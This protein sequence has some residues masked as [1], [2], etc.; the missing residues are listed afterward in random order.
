VFV[1]AQTVLGLVSHLGFAA[2][3]AL[4]V[5]HGVKPSSQYHSL[6]MR[7]KG[8]PAVQM[9]RIY[10]S[11]FISIGALLFAISLLL[12]IGVVH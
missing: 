3:G 4:L 1:S 5:Y 6:W 11:V 10:R 12:A 7:L 8:Q 9:N 2:V